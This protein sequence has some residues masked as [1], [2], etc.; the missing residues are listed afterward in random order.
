MGLST[1]K[2]HEAKKS[3]QGN[4]ETASTPVKERAQVP[5]VPKP[6]RVFEYL[7]FHPEN[8]ARG[9][10]TKKY[11]ANIMLGGVQCREIINIQ[12]GRVITRKN[13]VADYLKGSGYLLLKKEEVK[14][15]HKF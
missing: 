14:H 1:H 6:R 2:E 3:Q 7:F 5:I 8:P 11:I 10:I 12:N 15:E 4:K 13:Y 9:Y